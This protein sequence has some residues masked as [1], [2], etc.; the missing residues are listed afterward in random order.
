MWLNI[1]CLAITMVARQHKVK[2]HGRDTICGIH[3]QILRN[4]KLLLELF[5]LI[6]NDIMCVDFERHR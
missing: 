1:F 3:A 6:I 5:I 2:S 4:Y